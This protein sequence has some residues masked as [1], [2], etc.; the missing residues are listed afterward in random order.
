MDIK[1][2]QRWAMHGMCSNEIT[3]VSVEDQEVK[4]IQPLGDEEDRVDQQC[5]IGEL[6]DWGALSYSPPTMY[7]DLELMLDE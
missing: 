6:V 2:G 1:P 5:S 4:Y 3:I 7:D